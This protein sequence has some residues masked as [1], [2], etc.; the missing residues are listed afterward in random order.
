MKSE[1]IRT[2]EKVY[3]SLAYRRKLLAY[4]GLAILKNYVPLAME[5]GMTMQDAVEAWKESR[6]ARIDI[7]CKSYLRSNR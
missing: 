5:E 1:E 2:R 3:S 7:E 6:K 4:P